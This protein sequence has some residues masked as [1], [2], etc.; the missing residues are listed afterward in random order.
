MHVYIRSRS[1]SELERTP[2]PTAPATDEAM[3]GA[4]LSPYEL[5]DLLHLLLLVL[6]LLLLYVTITI[7][8]ILLIITGFPSGTIC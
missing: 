5:V 7:S 3:K 6:L 2:P 1:L 4:V 8:I